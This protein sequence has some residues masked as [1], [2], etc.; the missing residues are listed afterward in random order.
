M[1]S[2][3]WST[4]TGKAGDGRTVGRWDDMSW[5]SCSTKSS[6]A[7]DDDVDGDDVDD[8]D[9]DVDDDDD[10]GGNSLLNLNDL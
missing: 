7:D 4:A 1:S 5:T 8:D 6:G 10:E 2:L 9:D 3:F